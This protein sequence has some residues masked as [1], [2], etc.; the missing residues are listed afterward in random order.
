MLTGEVPFAGESV[1]TVIY[2]ILKHDPVPPELINPLVPE[3]AG[4]VV[5]R[6]LS[7]LPSARYPSCTALVEGLAETLGASVE[8]LGGSRSS[9]QLAATLVTAVPWANH[10]TPRRTPACRLFG[11]FSLRTLAPPAGG[12]T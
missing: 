4:E 6:A 12:F 2:G 7:K 11:P 10:G 1:T 8:N 3:A 5:I 9:T